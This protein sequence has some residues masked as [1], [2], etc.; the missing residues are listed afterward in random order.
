MKVIYIQ[1]N[2]RSE[3]DCLIDENNSVMGNNISKTN[4]STIGGTTNG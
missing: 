4:K 1:E 3:N 2:L